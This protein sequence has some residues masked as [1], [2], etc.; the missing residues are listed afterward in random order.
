MIPRR[1]ELISAFYKYEDIFENLSFDFQVKYLGS[2]HAKGLW[3]I[4]HTR[5]PVDHLVSCI[6]G[7]H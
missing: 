3:G 7:R 2:E 6:N 1:D 4:K 5:R